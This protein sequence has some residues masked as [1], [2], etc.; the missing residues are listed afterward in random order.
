MWLIILSLSS[1]I[2]SALAFIFLAIGASRSGAIS[3]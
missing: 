3:T 1:L 2:C